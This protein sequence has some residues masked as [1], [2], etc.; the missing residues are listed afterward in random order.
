MN[1]SRVGSFTSEQSQPSISMKNVIPGELEIKGSHGMQAHE[2][3]SMLSF[4][5]Q[6]I[7]QPENMIGKRIGLNQ[8]PEALINMDGFQ[9]AGVTINEWAHQY[10]LIF[11]SGS[12]CFVRFIIDDH[13]GND[14]AHNF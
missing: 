11:L 4:I 13:F 1:H 9:N 14:F 7:L 6:G 3:P 10:I 2:Y 12:G 5:E 8:V